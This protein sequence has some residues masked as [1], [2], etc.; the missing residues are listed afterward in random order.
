MILWGKI[1]RTDAS[2]WAQVARVQ[3]ALG[4]LDLNVLVSH[5]LTS[6]NEC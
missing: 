3:V 4:N 6:Q 1:V 5:E 2:A